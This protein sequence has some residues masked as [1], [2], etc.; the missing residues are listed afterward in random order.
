VLTL[1]GVGLVLTVAA[2]LLFTVQ[3]I[4]M[5]TPEGG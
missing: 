4:R 2:A 3:E 5:K 1:L